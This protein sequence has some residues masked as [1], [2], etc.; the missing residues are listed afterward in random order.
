MKKLSILFIFLTF[1]SCKEETDCCVQLERINVTLSFS[2]H[3]DGEPITSNDFN[4][5]KF[6]TKNGELISIERV[7]YVISDIKIGDQSFDYHLVNVNENSSHNLVLNNILQG[8]KALSF[9]FGFSDENNIDGA[10][11]DLNSVSFNVPAM[12]GGGYHY[13]Q[14]DGKFKDKD[15]QDANFNYHVIR[16][17]DNSDP[18]NL[19][20]QDT[21]FTFD[22][23]NKRFTSNTTVEIKMN[24]AEW[25]KNPHTWNLNELNTVL[26]PNFDAQILMNENGKNVFSVGEIKNE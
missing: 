17:A 8:D 12:L 16:A 1:F 23:S 14:F 25:F 11:Q 20:L 21:S 22:T 3:W 19:N 15:N 7:R 5:F 9:T 18:N 26:M 13:M 4:N 24:V 6:T 10:Y 2:H